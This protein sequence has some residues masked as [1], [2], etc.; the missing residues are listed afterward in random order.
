MTTTRRLHGLLVTLVAFSAMACEGFPG[1]Y[2]GDLTETRSNVNPPPMTP[3]EPVTLAVQA[4]V[5]DAPNDGLSIRLSDANGGCSLNGTRNGNSVTIPAGQSCS[6]PYESDGVMY[7]ITYTTTGG[8]GQLSTSSSST[9]TGTRRQCDRNG[10]NCRTV[11]TTRTS[12][13]VYLNLTINT[14]YQLTYTSEGMPVSEMGTSQLS[15]T[16]S[17]GGA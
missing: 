11:T 8:S 13:T 12:T 17:R 4:T 1:T 9:P 7:S 5:A 10:R 2:S 15:F 16:G 6:W 14:T 3:Y